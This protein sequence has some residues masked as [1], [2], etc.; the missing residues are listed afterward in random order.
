MLITIVVPIY[1]VEKYLEK[2]I[3]TLINQTY[4]NL[5]IILVNDG[6]PDNSLKICNQYLKEDNRIKII[7]KENGGLSDAR[8]AGLKMARGEYICFI[9]SDDYIELDMIEK[10][11]KKLLEEELDV[12]IFGLY[13]EVVDSNENII[14]QKKQSIDLVNFN[15]IISIIGYAWN[16]LYKTSFLKEKNITFTKGLSL[17]EDVVFNEKVFLKNI[18]IGYIN[19]PLYHYVSRNRSTLVKQYYE[20]SYN[21]H[22]QGNLSRKNIIFKIL[23]RNKKTEELLSESHINGIRYCCSNMFFYKNNLSIYEK[24]KNIKIIVEDNCTKEEIKNYKSK[25]TS[26]KLIEVCLKNNCPLVLTI[27]YFFK[28]LIAKNKM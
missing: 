9:D 14:N 12:V 18:K 17:I 16:K 24:Y 10:T 3:K 11:K 22:K 20:D 21:L 7:N 15:S 13:N 4:S 19:E 8:N 26:D 23:G 28:S 2:C 25:N 1:N 5:E 27:S 6:S